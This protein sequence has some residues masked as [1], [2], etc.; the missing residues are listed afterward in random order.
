MPAAPPQ[1]RDTMILSVFFLLLL[2]SAGAQAQYQSLPLQPQGDILVL[3]AGH[4]QGNFLIDQPGHIRCAANAVIDAGAQGHAV[5]ITAAEVSLEGC[6]IINWGRNLTDLDSAI[7]VAARADHVRL[8]NNHLQGAGFGIWAD[9]SQHIEIHGNQ[10]NGD[11]T[12]RSQDRGNGIHL[13][14]V[15]QA[16]VTDNVIRY[17][18][19]GI[20]IDTSNHNTLTGNVLEDLRYGIHYMFSNNNVVHNNTTRRTRTGYALMQSRNLDVRNNLSE[21]DQNY[22][23]LMNYITYSTISHNRV[24]GVIS[25]STG[26]SMIQGAEGKALFIYNSVFNTIS[27]NYFADSVMGIHLTAGSEDNKIFGN[28]FIANQQQVKYVA[29]RTQEWSE[30]GRGNYWSDYLG[31][32]R[33]VDDIGDLI[34]EPNDNIDRL[35]WLYPQMRLL[36]NSPAIELLR[37]V[38]QAF[39]VV[40]SPGVRDSFPL[41]RPP[42]TEAP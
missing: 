5:K 10:I 25:G 9:T 4:Y 28:A 37:W 7:F 32:D 31:W 2:A 14:S 22:G 6:H 18:R 13:F 19:D 42:L 1:L 29:T 38:Q 15:R 40:K 33:N 35:L 30:N 3:P 20:Y 8:L 12:V 23:I 11:N 41:M 36:L 17:T 27:H 21:D 34:Y 26:D 39:P 16:S 24:Q